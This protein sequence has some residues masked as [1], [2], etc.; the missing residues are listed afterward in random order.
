MGYCYYSYE[1]MWVIA[2]VVNWCV[3]RYRPGIVRAVSN[4]CLKVGIEAIVIFLMRK[5]DV[6]VKPAPI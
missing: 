4:F 6:F 3:W 1:I 5:V 2:K